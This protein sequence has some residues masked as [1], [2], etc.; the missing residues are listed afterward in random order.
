MRK[1][2]V[3]AFVTI[4]TVFNASA[5]SLTIYQRITF[6]GASSTFTIKAGE[7]LPKE[8]IFWAPSSGN[9]TSYLELYVTGPETLPV[10]AYGAFIKTTPQQALA[11]KKN[12]YEIELKTLRQVAR[13][14]AQC[15]DI[16]FE[17]PTDEGLLK[18]EDFPP[19]SNEICDSF[20]TEEMQNLI[21]TFHEV[22]GGTWSVGNMCAYILSTIADPTGPNKDQLCDMYDHDELALLGV[23]CPDPLF[24]MLGRSA[25]IETPPDIMRHFFGLFRKDSCAPVKKSRYLVMI[26][27]NLSKMDLSLYP[28]GLT[29][30]VS[31]KENKLK[32]GKEAALKP[33]SD[34]RYSPRPI[35]MMNYLNDN[36]IT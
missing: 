36:Q 3:L 20:S 8:V 18:P 9:I 13:E 6:D 4:C 17:M 22:Y 32:K 34:G 24:A 19:V 28:D 23:I 16:G 29:V 30:E 25:S 33:K 10:K 27:I 15:L 11:Q 21:D 14:Q 2:L 1:Y 12:R 35:I 31:V 26:S 5:E 7:S